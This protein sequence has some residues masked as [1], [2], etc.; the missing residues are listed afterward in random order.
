[1]RLIST[2]RATAAVLAVA[3]SVAAVPSFT[4]AQEM[5]PR[6]VGAVMVDELTT[7]PMQ[8]EIE[9]ELMASPADV[10]AYISDSTNA[11]DM[12]GAVTG[13]TVSGDGTSR[14]LTL[15]DG[16]TVTET[17]IVNDAGLM[18][19]AYSLPGDN[20]MGLSN[21][22]AVMQVRPADERDGSI[23]A[24]QQYFDGEGSE[25]AMALYT[26]AAASLAERFGGY[27]SGMHAGFADVTLTHTRIYN[28]SAEAVWAEVAENYAGAHEWSSAI[29]SIEFEDAGDGK[30]GDVRACF[31]PGLGGAT[32]EVITRYDEDTF[33]YAYTIE[34]GM[35][36]FVTT[37]EATWSA[38][39]IDDNTSE[40]TVTI[41]FQTA[42]GV[43]PQA[44][45]MARSQFYF[46]AGMGI[47]ELKY[48]LENGQPHPREMAT[49]S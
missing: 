45:A 27:S 19:F 4:V 37:N 10:F 3:A 32:R 16:S 29:A 18:S 46:F 36:P 28:V 17:I 11:D 40:V 1:M 15:A 5:P 24:W 47:D 31:I 22:L 41:N 21:H 49:R 6:V 25:A 44:I 23:L 48:F 8:F 38:T 35:P 26:E 30:I 7:A 42:P 20:P 14:E 39:P 2:F 33:T 43:P 34:E 12:I 13:V 9:V